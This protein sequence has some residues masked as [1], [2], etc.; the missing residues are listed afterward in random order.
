M[1]KGMKTPAAVDIFANNVA[2]LVLKPKPLVFLI[3]SKEVSDSYREFFKM[4]WKI[5]E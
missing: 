5:A 3:T 2:T 1:P 4:L